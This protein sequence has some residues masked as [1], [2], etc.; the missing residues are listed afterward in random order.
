MNAFDGCIAQLRTLT[1]IA[2]FGNGLIM[3]EKAITTY[4]ASLKND[5][6]KLTGLRNIRMA[7]IP[8]GDGHGPIREFGD[9]LVSFVDGRMAALQADQ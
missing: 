9:M 1:R 3:A 8:T 5:D 2:D 7:V 6:E 4:V